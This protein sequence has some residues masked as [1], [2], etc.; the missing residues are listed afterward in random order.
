MGRQVHKI[1]IHA[2]TYLE[3]HGNLIHT[4]TIFTLESRLVH[5]FC[6]T[7]YK[8]HFDFD[9]LVSLLAKGGSPRAAPR[10]S[11]VPLS[12]SLGPGKPLAALVALAPELIGGLI[13]QN[14]FRGELVA[15]P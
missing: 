5:T 6:R 7:D 15:L 12:G 11:V 3:G 9:V 14:A 4:I 8:L 10:R 2:Y 13:G 1:E